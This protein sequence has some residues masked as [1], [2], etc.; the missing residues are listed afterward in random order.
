MIAS[1]NFLIPSPVLALVK[2][3]SSSS[4]PK[5][6]SSSTTLGIL[7]LGRSILLITGIIDKLLSRAR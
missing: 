5:L 7:A 2:I 3:I 1:N 6:V 4:K